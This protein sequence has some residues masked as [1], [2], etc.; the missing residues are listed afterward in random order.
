M[1]LSATFL[2]LSLAL[3]A[4]ASGPTSMMITKDTAIVSVTGRD[5][6]ERMKVVETSLAEAARVTRRQGYRYFV[7]LDA[8]DAS[9]NGRRIVPIRR[10]R[11]GASIHEQVFGTVSLPSAVSV[12]GTLPAP[13]RPVTYFQPGL[14]I[15]IRMYRDGDVTPDRQGVWDSNAILGLGAPV[16]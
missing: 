5:N 10:V 3:G 6:S 14:D 9:R 7:I 4:C 16:R 13:G 1:R 12:Y 2:V 15:T 8:A 11:T